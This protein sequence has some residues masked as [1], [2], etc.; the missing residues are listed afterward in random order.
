MTENR[1]NV[2]NIKFQVT[3]MNIN[4]TDIFIKDM[5]AYCWKQLLD[6]S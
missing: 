2:G 1:E 4:Q 6:F 3:Q 5:L